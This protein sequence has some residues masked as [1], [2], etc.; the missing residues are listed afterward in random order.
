MRV[1]IS[2]THSVGKSRLCRTLK[3]KH[4]DWYVTDYDNM[5]LKPAEHNNPFG[6]DRLFE[7]QAYRCLLY[8]ADERKYNQIEKNYDT[9]IID[10]HPLDNLIYTSTLAAKYLSQLF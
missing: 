8:F 9:M 1:Y 5:G 10:R 7:R 2:G 6:F 3:E 4:P